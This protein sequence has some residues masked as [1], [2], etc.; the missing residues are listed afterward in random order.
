MPH[1]LIIEGIA[2]LKKRNIKVTSHN[3]ESRFVLCWKKNLLGYLFL[4]WALSREECS[5]PGVDS[6]PHSLWPPLGFISSLSLC[7]KADLRFCLRPKRGFG[8]Y[9]SDGLSAEILQRT[10]RPFPPPIDWEFLLSLVLLRNHNPTVDL[11]TLIW[12]K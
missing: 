11:F 2:C 4:S 9:L 7:S 8:V 10:K 5:G 12:Y 1:S 3:E 6:N